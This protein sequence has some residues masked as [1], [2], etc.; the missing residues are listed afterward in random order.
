MENK[1]KKGLTIIN[2]NRKQEKIGVNINRKKDK[3]KE[4]LK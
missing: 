2:C 3:R 1:V 4:R